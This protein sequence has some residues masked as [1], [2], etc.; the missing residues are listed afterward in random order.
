MCVCVKTLGLSSASTGMFH[1]GAG[2]LV[3]HF[4]AQCNAQLTET[5]A[6]QH[7]RVQLGQAESVH[8]RWRRTSAF[9]VKPL[10]K[11]AVLQAEEDR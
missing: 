1:N 2:D 3:L 6:E 10:A 11:T 9:T 8:G 7:N 5:L 4:V